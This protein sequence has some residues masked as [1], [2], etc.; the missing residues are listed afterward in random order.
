MT[1]GPEPPED[2]GRSR[3]F[4]DRD[5][6]PI[7]RARPNEPPSAPSYPEDFDDAPY[8]PMTDGVYADRARYDGPPS[9]TEDE[10]AGLR[11][12]EVGPVPVG[13]R[14]A[15]LDEEA[16]RHAARYLFPTEKFRG[17]WKRHWIQ[18]A[19]EG[20]VAI[21]ATVAMGYVAGWLTKHNQTQLRTVVLIIWAVVI[22]WCAW[23]VADWWYDRFILTNKRV[24]VVSGIFTR[25]VAMMPLLRVTDMKYVQSLTGRMFGYGHFELESAGQDQALRNIRNLPNPNELYLRIV[26]EMYE[27]EAV[28]ARLGRAATSEDDGT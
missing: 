3:R 22:L 6:E 20:L 7:P 2:E 15:P 19:K 18:L 9:F 26:E 16:S 12:G 5:T 14:V 24:M 23:R 17:E 4:E 10:F 28:E 27:P 13:S 8:D 21:G 11:S 25:N 1:T